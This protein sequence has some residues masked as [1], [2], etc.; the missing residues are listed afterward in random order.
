VTYI[1]TSAE[2]NILIKEQIG[3][4]INARFEIIHEMQAKVEHAYACQPTVSSVHRPLQLH[5]VKVK[6]QRK[7]QT[8]QISHYIYF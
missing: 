7:A 4:E 8:W 2:H 3:T 1:I 5:T 6:R